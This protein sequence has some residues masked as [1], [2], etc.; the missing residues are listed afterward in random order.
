MNCTLQYNVVFLS[1]MSMKV[2]SI[3]SEAKRALS[4]GLAVVIGLQTTGEVGHTH[5]WPHSH[6]SLTEPGNVVSQQYIHIYHSCLVLPQSSLEN[7]VSRVEGDLDN[8]VSLTQEI[9]LRF[10]REHFP[11]TIHSQ[12]GHV[13][14]HVT[15]H[16][17]V[18]LS[19]RHLPFKT[20]GVSLQK[21]CCSSLSQKWSYLTGSLHNTHRHLVNHCHMTAHTVT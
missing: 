18:S 7:E 20:F 12:V 6:T 8:F 17:L 19:L 21:I 13:T 4:E 10:L 11:T 9:L 15:T 3:V 16:S 1:S 14:C 5:H 2:P